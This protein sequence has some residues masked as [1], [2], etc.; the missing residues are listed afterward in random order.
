MKKQLEIERKFILPQIPEELIHHVQGDEIKQGY[1]LRESGRELRIRQRNHD[2]RMTLKQGGGLSRIEQE[3][4]I[5]AEQFEMLWP[6]TAGRQIEKIRYTIKQEDLLFEIDL[7]K[8]NLVPLIILE[9]EFENLEQS[10]QFQVPTF[11]SR[12]VTE[13]E[14]YKNAILATAGLPDSF[15]TQ[16][17]T[18]AM[19]K[20]PQ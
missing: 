19:V 11:A 18:A 14:S 17:S 8:G 13:D 9:V 16:Q 1:L 5:P 20:G 3:C 2:Y 10:R 6:L 4:P 15:A 12:E 7:F